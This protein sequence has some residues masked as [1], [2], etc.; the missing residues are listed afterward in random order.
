MTARSYSSFPEPPWSERDERRHGVFPRAFRL[1][2]EP[3]RG[4]R[5]RRVHRGLR[6]GGAVQPDQDRAEQ[7]AGQR[8]ALLSPGGRDRH[9]GR[10]GYRLRVGVRPVRRGDAGVLRAVPPPV[11]A[12]RQRVQ[13]S[14]GGL[15]PQPLP[16]GADPRRFT[17]G[18]GVTRRVPRARARVLPPAPP[19]PRRELLLLLGLYGGLDPHA[20]RQRRGVLHGHVARCGRAEQGAQELPPAAQPRRLLRDL[21]RVPGLQGQPGR[22]EAHGARALR[23]AL[24]CEPREARPYPP[25]APVHGRVRGEPLYAL[26]RPPSLGPSFHRSVRRAV[27]AAAPRPPANRDPPP[28]PRLQRAVAARADRPRTGGGAGWGDRRPVAL[29]RRWWRDALLHERQG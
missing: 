18:A 27:R 1:R 4:P 6:R 29:P 5:A 15:P 14:P 2:T 22:G 7:P 20:G 23:A 3:I 8:V 10:R 25:L 13:P 26:P 12:A 11:P 17:S 19:L 16:P 9:R 24:R 21:H 28:R